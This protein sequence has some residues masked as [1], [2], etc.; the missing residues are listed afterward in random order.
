[1]QPIAFQQHL[2]LADK[3]LIGCLIFLSLTSY[4]IIRHMM[5]EGDTVQIE[6]NGTL[7][8]TMPLHSEQTLSVPGPLGK[9]EVI[10]KE[11]KVFVS[12]SPCRNKICVRTGEISYSGQLIAC[13][14]NKVV[15]R[16]IGK[17][18]P[19]LPYDAITR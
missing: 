9:T 3:V 16:V 18:D 12:A 1:M 2:T 19:D 4:P 5:N 14:P 11:G 8:A 17:A 7:Y 15:I 13:V 10:I 6:V